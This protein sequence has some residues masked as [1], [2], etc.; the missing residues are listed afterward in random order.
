MEGINFAADDVEHLR[1]PT[2]VGPERACIIEQHATPQQQ[3]IMV[4]RKSGVC[5]SVLLAI[6]F[7]LTEL[8][9]SSSRPDEKKR[10]SNILPPSGDGDSPPTQGRT[11]RVKKE[12]MRG[13][14]IHGVMRRR[15]CI[16]EQSTA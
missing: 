16:V 7:C 15:Q 11:I 10:S 3:Q 13:V 4:S 12:Q 2:N 1:N 5:A 14:A 9:G 6:S 8:G